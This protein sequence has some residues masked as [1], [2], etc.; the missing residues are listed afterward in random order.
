M[1]PVE[2]VS[3]KKIWLWSLIIALG[4]IAAYI[5]FLSLVSIW[6]GIDHSH[7]AGFWI[8]TRQPAVTAIERSDVCVVPRAGVIS[9]AML[10]F[11][12]GEA[13]IE[14]FGGDHID[15]MKRNFTHY[16]EW[17]GKY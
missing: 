14:K 10:A 11:V 8:K 4:L 15:E 17:L 2:P 13:M 5:G 6:I 7:Q 9:E 3:F 12:L 1:I 16:T